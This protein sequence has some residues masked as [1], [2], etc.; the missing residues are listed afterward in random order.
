M[1][2]GKEKR[3]IEGVWSVLVYKPFETTK[4]KQCGLF[5]LL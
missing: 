2:I 5:F 1:K 3:V 4:T